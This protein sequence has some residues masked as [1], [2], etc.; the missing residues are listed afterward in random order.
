MEGKY[1][2]S[3]LHIFASDFH[4]DTLSFYFSQFF[5]RDLV[6]EL[7]F[8]LMHPMPEDDIP[9]LPPRASPAHSTAQANGNMGDN[10]PV[11]NNLIQLDTDIAYVF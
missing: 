3:N 5:L 11:D 9:A 4:S 6:A 10:V 8:T 1:F 2:A 7:P